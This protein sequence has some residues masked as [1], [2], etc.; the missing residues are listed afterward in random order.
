M[1]LYTFKCSKCENVFNAFCQTVA[2][3]DARGCDE[4]DGEA[5]RKLSVT[6]DYRHVWKQKRPPDELLNTKE[7]WE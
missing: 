2:R 5:M 3:N 6:Q 7:I 4:C 1:P